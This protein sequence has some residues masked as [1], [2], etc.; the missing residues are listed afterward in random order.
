MTS[1]Q[2]SVARF[3]FKEITNMSKSRF[4]LIR[5]CPNTSILAS[6]AQVTPTT[7]H[8]PLLGRPGDVAQDE[9]EGLAHN[10]VTGMFTVSNSVKD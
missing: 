2:V 5:F 10:L 7:E 8:E 6:V 9:R 3:D 4:L 1:L